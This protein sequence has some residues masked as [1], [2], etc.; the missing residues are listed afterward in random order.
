M[1]VLVQIQGMVQFNDQATDVAATPYF[2]LEVPFRQVASLIVDGTPVEF[3]RVSPDT[4]ATTGAANAS[5]TTKGDIRFGAKFYI[6]RETESVP[7]IGLRLL[8]KSATG[9]GLEDRRF[10]NAPAYMVDALVA[11]TV[12]EGDGLLRRLRIMVQVGVMAWQLDYPKQDDAY[13]WGVALQAAVEPGLGLEL[14]VRGYH[15]WDQYTSP[16]VAALEASYRLAPV[17]FLVTVNR[18]LSRDAPDWGVRAGLEFAFAIP[19]L[20]GPTP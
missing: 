20:A 9:K 15:G 17:R 11:K 13:D 3:W 6:V 10:T 18:G 1:D 4:Q 12:L 8:Y 7:A 14:Q 16:I 5:G 19:Y 2:R